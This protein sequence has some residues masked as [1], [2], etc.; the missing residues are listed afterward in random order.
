MVDSHS[1]RPVCALEAHVSH[2]RHVKV[3]VLP[4]DVDPLELAVV[5]LG[6]I[7]N[8]FDVCGSW[9]V[10]RNDASEVVFGEGG[11]LCGLEPFFDR[12]ICALDVLSVDCL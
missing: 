5:E 6:S 7:R 8:V 12:Q 4:L 1:L 10:T 11:T 3:D 2:S 9:F